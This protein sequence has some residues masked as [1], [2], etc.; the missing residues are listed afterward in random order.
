MVMASSMRFLSTPAFFLSS[1]TMLSGCGMRNAVGGLENAAA[2]RQQTE[3]LSNAIDDLQSSSADWR[4]V[5]EDTESKLTQ[6][7]QATVR[8]EIAN[9]LS[10]T[11]AQAGVEFRCDADFINKRV[12]E[13]LIAIK[14]ASLGQSIPA[15][16][17]SFCR[18]VPDVVDRSAVPQ[19]VKQLSFYGYNFDHV[20]QLHVRLVNMDGSTNDVTNSVNHP[21]PYAMTLSFGTTGVRLDDRSLRLELG[22]N[23][24][25]VASV[26]VIQPQALVPVCASKVVPIFAVDSRRTIGPFVPPKAGM[27]DAEFDGHGP[28][29]VISVALA[30]SSQRVAARVFMDAME[31]EADWTEVEGWQDYTLYQAENGWTIDHVDR[32]TSS[33]T[34]Y[35]QPNFRKKGP[36]VVHEISTGPSD[37]VESYQIIG[38]THGNDVGRTSVSLRFNPIAVTLTQVANCASGPALQR[39]IS[40]HML[41]RATETALR[42]QLI[43]S[44]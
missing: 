23:Q 12:A 21:T 31:T 40:A 36:P 35:L 29:I 43:T 8:D 13:D 34:H 26:G 32:S 25:E 42:E 4:Q 37:L 27:G 44:K 15:P 19:D 41:S 20:D 14:A 11:I 10:R 16:R 6:D 18:V 28:N 30:I 33:S 7:S 2:T 17:P 1:L 39:A 5:L 24:T 9:V 22:W 38:D 3:A